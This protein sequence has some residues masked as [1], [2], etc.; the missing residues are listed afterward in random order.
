MKKTIAAISGRGN[1]APLE[2]EMIGELVSLV[3]K[4]NLQDFARALLCDTHELNKLKSATITLPM[5]FYYV[6]DAV[7]RYAKEQ[8]E[9]IYL[10]LRGGENSVLNELFSDDEL[11]EI[12]TLG[13]G[14]GIKSKIETKIFSKMCGEKFKEFGDD[15]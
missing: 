2:L 5:V 1:F 6:K 9:L 7:R 12:E 14:D 11:G 10:R 13:W 3:P 4:D 15:G 8:S